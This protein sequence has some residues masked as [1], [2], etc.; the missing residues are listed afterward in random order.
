MITAFGE[1]LSRQRRSLP[2]LIIDD[3]GNLTVPDKL[4]DTKLDLTARHR[5]AA[6]P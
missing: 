6:A 1:S 3:D 5:G 2:A 4:S